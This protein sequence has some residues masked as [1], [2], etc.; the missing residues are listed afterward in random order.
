[1]ITMNDRRA[2][3]YATP[4]VFEAFDTL[5][6]RLRAVSEASQ[7]QM[8]PLAAG[9]QAVAAAADQQRRMAEM[10]MSNVATYILKPYSDTLAALSP[11]LHAWTPVAPMLMTT[12]L[13]ELADQWRAMVANLLRPLQ[14]L[15]GQ[16]AWWRRLH[17][18]LIAAAERAHAVLRTDPDIW[19]R[20]AAVRDFA[21]HWIGVGKQTP[22]RREAI[23]EAVED[24]LLSACWRAPEDT[25]DLALGVRLRSRVHAEARWHRPIW[26]N[27]VRGYLIDRL[28]RPLGGAS[29]GELTTLAQQVADPRDPYVVLEGGLDA[30][31]RLQPVMQL[32]KPEHRLV[33]LQH[34]H[35]DGLTWQEAALRAGLP[36]EV[37]ESARRRVRR[38]SRELQRRQLG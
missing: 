8:A 25:A 6:A 14:W 35:G 15:A 21:V 36:A 30:Q 10:I 13:V 5:L 23:L 11:A 28:E 24:V 12:S 16:L 3:V 27:Q 34:A 7:I 19:R 4:Q 26:E 33:V 9:L 32:L 2:T 29:R 31:R 20:K 22:A 17:E 1:M 37:G 18:A 38:L